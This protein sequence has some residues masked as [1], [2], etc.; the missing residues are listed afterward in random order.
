MQN[1]QPQS[2]GVIYHLR[3]NDAF[4]RFRGT[5][6]ID[7]IIG[8]CTKLTQIQSPIKQMLSSHV[9]PGFVCQT[10]LE[11]LLSATSPVA[12]WPVIMTRA[13]LDQQLSAS[14]EL[15]I[16]PRRHPNTQSHHLGHRETTKIEIAEKGHTSQ[17]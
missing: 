2:H 5:N 13:G 7:V 3:R 11:L 17:R 14:Y 8:S 12:A 10:A 4:A 16:Q 1:K 9:A 15:I 6:V